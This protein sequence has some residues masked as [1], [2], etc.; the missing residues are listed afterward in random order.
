LFVNNILYT[1]RTQEHQYSNIMYATSYTMA[2]CFDRKQ[3]SSGQ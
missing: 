3:S 1:V 2:T